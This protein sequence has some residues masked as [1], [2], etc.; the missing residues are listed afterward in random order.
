MQ[1]VQA[2]SLL[3]PSIF[4]INL[5][6]SRP[7]KASPQQP[8]GTTSPVPTPP[9]GS[10]LPPVSSDLNK[11]QTEEI[12]NAILPPRYVFAKVFIILQN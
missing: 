7:L 2:F 10:K 5:F 4:I 9:K 8:E 6:Q 3:V 1:H 11:N 12:L